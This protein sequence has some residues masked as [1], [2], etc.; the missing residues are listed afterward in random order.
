M[1][2]LRVPHNAEAEEALL[3]ALLAKP[4]IAGEVIGALL[5]PKHFYLSAN[6]MIF[7]TIIDAYYG[8]EVID[9][10]TIGERCVKRV[11]KAWDC[12]DDEAI[13]RIQ[14]MSQPTTIV[15]AI[16]YAKII[17]AH[18]DRRDLLELARD[19]ERKVNDGRT[20]PEE[21]AGLVSQTGMQIA[22]STLLT[23]EIVDV[24][25]LGRRFNREMQTEIAARENGEQIGAHFNLPFLDN[26]LRGFR[27]GRTWY[28]AGD[29]GAGK[30]AI[31]WKA[32]LNFAWQ[33]A[34]H[35]NKIGTFVASMEMGEG[36]SNV[37]LAQMMA[38]M[39]SEPIESGTLNKAQ[40]RHI[41]NSWKTYKDLPLHFNFSSSLRASQ[42][43]ALVV[44]AIR[45]HN[46]GLVIVDHF[47]HF[48]MDRRYDSQN[49]ED[50]AKAR[51]LQQ[52][53]A[54]DLNVAVIVLA[55]LNKG[56]RPPGT[57]PRLKH[58]RG[59]GQ[60]AAY[61]NYVSFVYRPFEDATEKDQ[62]N[63]IPS[64]AEMIWEK[65]R[66]GMTGTAEFYFNPAVMDIR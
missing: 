54:R 35:S 14:A 32:G 21:V 47:R 9:P 51:F 36:D 63:Y 12:D 10:L 60:I 15:K 3:G 25:E 5:E 31:A 22:T 29:P 38:R 23:H 6:R 50:E 56:D 59:S 13:R 52:S 18:S 24:G 34:Q 1:S 65:N 39:D 7:E 27:P 37:R 19:I 55:H 61:A 16:E 44:E 42:L 53:I 8:D 49:E 43:R 45:K 62:V 17:K 46:V 4:L 20:A 41:M 66:H 64:D 40:L 58:L 26:H 30:S 33:Q 28:L 48:D 2:T 57:R 11:V